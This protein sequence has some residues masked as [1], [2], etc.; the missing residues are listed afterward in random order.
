ME[1]LAIVARLKDGAEAEAAELLT[2]GAPFDPEEHG[3]E[4]HAVYLSAGEVVFVFEGHEVD[5]LVDTI[6]TEPFHWDVTTAFERWREL[7]EG[8]PR[9]ARPAYVWERRDRNERAEERPSFASVPR[10]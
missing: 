4:R 9:I 6:V 1:K 7:V 2:N 5:C 8:P 10:T 3:F